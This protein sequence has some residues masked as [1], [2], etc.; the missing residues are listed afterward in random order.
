MAYARDARAKFAVEVKDFEFL[1]ATPYPLA[2]PV[3]PHFP[4][5]SSQLFNSQVLR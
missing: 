5:T 4:I 2:S 1:S 3:A